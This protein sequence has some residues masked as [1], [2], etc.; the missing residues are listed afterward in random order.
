MEHRTNAIFGVCYAQ[1]NNIMATDQAS[2]KDKRHSYL[3]WSH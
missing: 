1:T 3:N 2:V